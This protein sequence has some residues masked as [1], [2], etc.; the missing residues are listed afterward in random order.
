M[1]FVASERRTIT[2]VGLGPGMPGHLTIDARAH[3]KAAA[4]AGS[5]VL[6]T[7]IH[8][9]VGA[10]DWLRDTPSYDHVYDLGNSFDSV[11]DAIVADLLQ[12]AASGPVTYGVPG[13]PTI[14]EA[15]VARLRTQA[16]SSDIVVDEIGRA[17]V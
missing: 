16:R 11:Y 12:R 4:S 13:H 5:L 10:I 6:R 17:H 3:L 9:T 7:R 8:P 15:T 2:V 14:G 1:R